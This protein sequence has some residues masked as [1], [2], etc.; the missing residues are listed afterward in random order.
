MNY[1][2]L[3]LSLLAVLF[4]TIASQAQKSN[5]A[6]MPLTQSLTIGDEV[7][8]FLINDIYFYN[9]SSVE[10]QEFRNKLILLDWWSYQCGTCIEAMPK[11]DS[12]QKEF[13]DKLIILPIIALKKIDD[14]A[15][16]K[17]VKFWTNNKYTKNVSLPSIMDTSLYK[18]FKPQGVPSIFWIDSAQVVRAITSSDRVN[19]K[20][21]K[22]FDPNQS[23]KW[24]NI[25]KLDFDYSTSLI[26]SNFQNNEV[27]DRT[28]LAILTKYLQRISSNSGIDSNKHFL[29][30]YAINQNI[31]SLYAH[32]LLLN[33]QA[34]DNKVLTESKL[35]PVT[36]SFSKYS[37]IYLEEWNQKNL[38]S[39]EII[40]RKGLTSNQIQRLIVEDLNRKLGLRA[41]FAMR[42]TT[43]IVLKHQ[44]NRITKKRNQDTS[45]KSSVEYFSSIGELFERLRMTAFYTPFINELSVS[46]KSPI[47]IP[48]SALDLSNLDVTELNKYLNYYGYC[49]EK[50]EA[51]FPV[52][53]VQE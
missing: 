46:I 39:Y 44:K 35:P 33:T 31:E 16:S 30:Y 4:V 50:K 9:K 38:F 11:L 47:I 26:D 25:N 42:L 24:E 7:P 3:L 49:L 51:E 20:E 10:L 45:N 6:S 37:G 19:R 48:S 40:L 13:K 36:K 27:I 43:S 2:R 18:I 41:A 8:N 1:N 52:L 29:R 32:A 14:S 22:F 28:K 5:A 21:L 34:R 23:L 17:L 15:K 12:L 53:V